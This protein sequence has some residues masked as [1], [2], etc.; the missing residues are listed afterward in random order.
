MILL[1]R[2]LVLAALFFWQGGFTFYAAVVVPVGRDVLTPM[3]QAFVTQP[4]TWYLNLSGAAALALLVWDTVAAHGPSAGRRRGRWLC[5]AG[6][7]V[8]LGLL[9][10]LHARLD[11]LLDADGA[12]VLDRKAFRFE[13]RCYLWVSTVQW[14]LGMVYTWLSLEVWR[15]EDRRVG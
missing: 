7:A 4:V 14:F 8:A 3:G 13:H 11:A 5:W 10:W 2:F 6:M 1:R 9:F 12:K 15:G